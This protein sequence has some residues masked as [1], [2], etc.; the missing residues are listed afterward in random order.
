MYPDPFRD[1]AVAYRHLVRRPPEWT[2]HPALV[3]YASLDGIVAAIRDDRPDSAGSDAAL[4]T[5]AAIAREDRRA[6]TVALY[7]LAAELER[8]LTR[9]ATAEYRVDALGELAAVI[10]EGDT[11]GRGLGHRYVNRAHNR[12]H[13][14]HHRVR[15]H[16]RATPSTV[17]PLPTDRVID[18]HDRQSTPIDIADLVAARVDLERFGAAV[19]IAIAKGDFAEQTWATY[20]EHRLRVVYLPDRPPV[21]TRARVAAYRAAKKVQ[22]LIET[23]L[24]GHA[25]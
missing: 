16:G 25:A 3:R 9:A 11:T 15:H 1:L 22:P 6:A 2:G 4:R 5:L 12:T 20:A 21:P 8:R 7:G 17:D 24:Q 13:K 19:A 10:L 23:Y 14:H 18:Y